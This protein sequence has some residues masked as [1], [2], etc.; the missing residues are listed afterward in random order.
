[1]IPRYTRAELGRLWTDQARMETWQ[2]VEVAASEELPGLLGVDGPS[3]CRAPRRSATPP[4]RSR[5]STSAS[6]VT[7]HDLAALVDV[8]GA[9]AG[10]AGRWIHFGLTSSDVLDTSLALS[11]GP[12]AR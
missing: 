10:E 1:M 5:P 6:A 11:Y 2:R 3:Q 12:S 8:L 9:S 7:D 4:S